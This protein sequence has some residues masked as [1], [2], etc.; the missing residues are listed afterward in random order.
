MALAA[1][2]EMIVDRNTQ[3]VEVAGGHWLALAAT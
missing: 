3:P 2:H 1:D